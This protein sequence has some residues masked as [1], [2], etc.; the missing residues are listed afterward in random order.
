MIS[1]PVRRVLV[2]VL[3]GDDGSSRVCLANTHNGQAFINK[4]QPVPY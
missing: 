2:M 3:I 1:T 4:Y